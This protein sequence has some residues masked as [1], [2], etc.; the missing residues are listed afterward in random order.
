MCP[1]PN[2]IK[3]QISYFTIASCSAFLGS[4]CS[5]EQALRYLIL[6]PFCGG[7]NETRVDNVGAGKV[8]QD[9]MSRSELCLYLILLSREQT[10][11]LL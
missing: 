2:A 8:I 6:C 7:E 9:K 11:V 10:S 5:L 4:Y 1:V 3:A